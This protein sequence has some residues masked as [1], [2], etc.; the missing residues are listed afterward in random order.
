MAKKGR[1][2]DYGHKRAAVETAKQ[3]RQEQK[4]ED[5]KARKAEKAE[6]PAEA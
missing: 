1:G 6:R 5:Q 4:R 3:K 2:N